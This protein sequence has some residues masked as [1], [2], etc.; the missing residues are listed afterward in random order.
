MK[1]LI[2]M[3]LATALLWSLVGCSNGDLMLDQEP[4]ISYT[5]RDGIYISVEDMVT[6]DGATVLN[7]LW[8]NE[9]KYEAVY[10]VAYTIQREEDGNWVE[11][12]T[13][14]PYFIE[15][16]YILEPNSTQMHSY[17]ISQFFDVSKEGTYRILVDCSLPVGDKESQSVQTWAAFTLTEEKDEDEIGMTVPDTVQ[18][19]RT[20]GDAEGAE[21]PDVKVIRSREE[22]ENYYR[23]NQEK[24][25][26]ERRETQH[27]YPSGKSGDRDL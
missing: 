16:A 7:V 23:D 2:A 15:I 5:S 12:E 25:D 13:A 4:E 11:C 6:K 9:T 19:I 3:F 27:L 10:G 1:K 17:T 8:H 18:Y 26:L 22:L 20:D 14:D 24:F 21:F